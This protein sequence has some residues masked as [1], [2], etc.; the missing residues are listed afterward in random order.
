MIKRIIEK[1]AIITKHTIGDYLKAFSNT[2][3]ET[4][5]LLEERIKT[6]EEKTHKKKSKR[7][8]PKGSKNKKA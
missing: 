3:I 2:Y 4:I 6:L 5:K 8:R 7:G 1:Y